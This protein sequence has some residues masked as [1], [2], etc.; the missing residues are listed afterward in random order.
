MRSGRHFESF[1]SV[2]VVSVIVIV[3]VWGIDVVVILILF[4]GVGIGVGLIG[5]RHL[6]A[7]PLSTI[8]TKRHIE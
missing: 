7:F 1:D 3:L 5:P 6:R 8:I 2:V 4:I